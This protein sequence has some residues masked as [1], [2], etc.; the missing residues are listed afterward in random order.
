[1]TEKTKFWKSF[2]RYNLVSILATTVDFVSFVILTKVFCLWY[3][4]STIVSAFLG[5]VTAFWLNRNWVF[6]SK[7]ENATTQFSKY[8]L[9]WIGSVILNTSGIFFLV[10]YLQIDEVISKVIVSVVVGVSF[11]FLI[12]KYF[13]FNK[14]SNE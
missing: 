11:N 12:S 9:G 2:F 13:N 6:V 10:E 3:V 14:I 4:M 1:M 7:E 5:G 8:A